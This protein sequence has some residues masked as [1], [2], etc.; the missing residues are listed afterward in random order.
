MNQKSPL[1]A[2]NPRI[3]ARAERPELCA[4]FRGFR[5]AIDRIAPPPAPV[6]PDCSFSIDPVHGVL[7]FT[8]HGAV[9]FIHDD[10][11]IYHTAAAII[12]VT[13]RARDAAA[14][15]HRKLAAGDSDT[16][17]SPAAKA[18]AA[19]HLELYIAGLVARWIWHRHPDREAVSLPQVRVARL[20]PR[21]LRAFRKQK[22][23]GTP[24]T[25]GILPAT[26]RNG[27][28]L[29]AAPA[30]SRAAVKPSCFPLGRDGGSTTHTRD[31]RAETPSRNLPP[32]AAVREAA[33]S[34]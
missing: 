13:E 14:R 4:T 7:A 11:G 32:V 5:E 10:I 25:A 23:G 31:R 24:A 26:A 22:T 2:N 15:H 18:A 9:T 29:C 28:G 27:G 20:S 6:A 33:R 16:L 3:T 30:G 1:P 12:A 19:R 21:E 8:R 17:A 34:E